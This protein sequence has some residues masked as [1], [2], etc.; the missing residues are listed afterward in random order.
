V[1]NNIHND[2]SLSQVVL[3]E[4]LFVMDVWFKRWLILFIESNVFHQPSDML[5]I[6][7][8]YLMHVLKSGARLSWETFHWH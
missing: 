2:I 1:Q 7:S 3:T 4:Y 8:E 5:E 6:Y